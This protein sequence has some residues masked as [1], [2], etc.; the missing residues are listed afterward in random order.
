MTPLPWFY[1]YSERY[2]AMHY[3]LHSHIYMNPDFDVRPIKVD[4]SEFAKTTYLESNTHF[5]AGCFIKQAMILQILKQLPTDSYFIFSDVDILVVNSNGL[6]EMFQEYMDKNYD[7]VYCWENSD[8]DVPIK[9]YNIGVS[10]IKV[11]EKTIKFFENFMEKSRTTVNI[12]DQNLLCSM[13]PEFSG[14]IGVFDKNV[15]IMSNFLNDLETTTNIKI[16]QV[17][18]GNNRDYHLN[19]QEKYMSM[20][21]LG[22]PIQECIELALQNGRSLDE[23]GLYE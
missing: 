4:Q 11:T 10:L 12:L 7:M 17:L 19:M 15:V 5:L 20:Q 22:A 13:L 6:L 3:M 21:R 2:E 14:S 1:V 18:C 9:N 16:I 23:L 8:Q